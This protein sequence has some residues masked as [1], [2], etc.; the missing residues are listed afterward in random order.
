MPFPRRPGPSPTWSFAI[1]PPPRNGSSAGRSLHRRRNTHNLLDL[2]QLYL[3]RVN[4][5]IRGHT[6]S[7]G[8]RT[9]LCRPNKL[10]GRPEPCRLHVVL[11][12]RL[13][14]STLTDESA[15]TDASALSRK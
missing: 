11:R 4:L 6:C 7:I 5:Y 13:D 8:Y 12:L 3:N 9:P 2:T 10:L 14:A 1:C 15:V